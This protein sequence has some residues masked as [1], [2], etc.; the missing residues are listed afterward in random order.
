MN[1]NRMRISVRVLGAKGLLLML[2]ACATLGTLNDMADCR[3]PHMYG[4][5][6]L[7]LALINKQDGDLRLRKNIPAYPILDLP[8]SFA[9]DTVLLPVSF[10]ATM[11]CAVEFCADWNH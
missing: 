1:N 7:D 11:C 6:R 10:S 3:Q 2:N 5:T 4:G 8:F 9:A